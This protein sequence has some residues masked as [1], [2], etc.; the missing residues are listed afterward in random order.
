MPG[1]ACHPS[2]GPKDVLLLPSPAPLGGE[3]PLY[4]CATPHRREQNQWIKTCLGQVGMPTAL[5]GEGKLD[6]VPYNTVFVLFH[7]WCR[8]RRALWGPLWA[9][10]P[11]C[12]PS[13]GFGFS[14]DEGATAELCIPEDGHSLP[15]TE[16]F[17]PPPPQL[18]VS[19]S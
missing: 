11:L 8:A 3:G 5:S 6:T 12:C 4:C 2:K 18:C 19:P 16:A 7:L 14:E 9:M 10:T 17:S 13:R 1:L 15:L